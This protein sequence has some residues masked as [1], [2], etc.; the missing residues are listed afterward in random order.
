[1]KLRFLIVCEYATLGQDNKLTIAG[2]IDSLSATVPADVDTSAGPFGMP[3]MTIVAGVECSIAEGTKHRGSLR[4]LNG[5]G[6]RVTDEDIDL[7]E[8]NMIVNSIGAPLRFNS[9]LHLNNLAV[10]ALDDL[11]FELRVDGELLGD[12]TVNLVVTRAETP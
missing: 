7:G 10:S 11:V 3:K 2:A 8:W 12:T 4:L 9:I 5:S 1:M 6:A